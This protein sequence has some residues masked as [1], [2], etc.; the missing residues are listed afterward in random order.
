MFK[1]IIQYVCVPLSHII[2]NS[3]EQGKF[4]DILKRATVTP[5]LKS[6]SEKDLRNYRPISV[7][8]LL[9]KVF[10]K[11]ICNRLISFLSKNNVLSRYQFGFQKKKS[12]TDA[13]LNYI[14]YV[15]RQLNGKSHTVGVALDFSKAFDTVSHDILLRKLLKYGIRGLAFSW[16]RSYL[17]GRTQKVRLSGD[18][19]CSGAGFVKSGVPQGSN[20][21]PILFL[22]YINDLP[23]V[24]PAAHITLFAD[25]ATLTLTSHDYD[26]MI[27]EATTNLSMVYDWTLNNRLML[28]AE[29]SSAILFTNGIVSVI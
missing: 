13:L 17:S 19:M 25:S 28:N 21:G 24:S 23:C 1:L 22:L 14:E 18:G 7:L 9:S 20:L 15:Y 16:F 5:V 6:G 3:I 27:N 26:T 12:T 10:E 29:K 8:P 4:P 2:N 11:C